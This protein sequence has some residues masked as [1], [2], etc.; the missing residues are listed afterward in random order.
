MCEPNAKLL[1][2]QRD[3][4]CHTLCKAGKRLGWGPNAEVGAQDATLPPALAVTA[5][6]RQAQRRLRGGLRVRACST[7]FRAQIMILLQHYTTKLVRGEGKHNLP[8]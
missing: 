3:G 6:I 1:P 8:N 7:D 4:A 5:E 2:V